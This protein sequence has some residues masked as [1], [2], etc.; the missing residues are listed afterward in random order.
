[1]KAVGRRQAAPRHTPAAGRLQGLQ[2]QT[3]SHK[4]VG[5]KKSPLKFH[6]LR[7]TPQ[8]WRLQLLLVPRLVGWGQKGQSC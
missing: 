1:M 5:R 2:T 7:L 6:S 3:A 4:Y 8:T